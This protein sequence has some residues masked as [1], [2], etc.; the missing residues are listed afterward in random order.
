MPQDERPVAGAQID[1]L[2]AVDVPLPAPLRVSMLKREGVDVAGR[3]VDAA[4][5][6]VRARSQSARDPRTSRHSFQRS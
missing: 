4:G 6:S 1:E 2:V 3:R 5:M